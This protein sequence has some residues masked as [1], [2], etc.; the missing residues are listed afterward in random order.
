MKEERRGNLR[1]RKKERQLCM[2][3]WVK[4]QSFLCTYVWIFSLKCMLHGIQW[5]GNY[6][7]SIP[8]NFLEGVTKLDPIQRNFTPNCNM[9]VLCLF[10]SL[11][12]PKLT[13]P[14]LGDFFY[15]Y[16]WLLLQFWALLSLRRGLS[17]RMSISF[18][19]CRRE[20]KEI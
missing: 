5:I 6:R 1:E 13:S 15:W 4:S 20:L 14:C 8:Y 3:V 17:S 9:V 11:F 19:S 10:H 12:S 16:S 2:C 7:S 18:Y